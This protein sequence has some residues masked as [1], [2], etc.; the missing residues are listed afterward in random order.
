MKITGADS[1][2]RIIKQFAEE[3]GGSKSRRLIASALSKATTPTVR[4]MRAKAPKSKG[5]KYN[6]KAI[7]LSYK[8]LPIQAGNLKRSIR[9]RRG[10]RKD[11][12]QYSEIGV[13][14]EAFYGVHFLPYGIAGTGKT[15]PSNW[16]KPVFAKNADMMVSIYQKDLRTK[17][18]AKARQLRGKQRA[19]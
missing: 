13:L 15:T 5:S 9:K 11:G 3:F 17:M 18:I 6:S 7:R 4:E 16:F 14:P 10:T 12:V 2:A 8:G 19:R 1:T